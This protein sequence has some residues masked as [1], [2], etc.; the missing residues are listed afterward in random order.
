MHPKIWSVINYRHRDWFG[1][2][3]KK[4]KNRFRNICHRSFF[5]IF[6]ST[7]DDDFN[8]KC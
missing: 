4:K 6:S 8:I 2:T 1:Q 3:Q 7:T 5:S